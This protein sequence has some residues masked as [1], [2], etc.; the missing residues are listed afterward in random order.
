MVQVQR[1]A[2]HHVARMLDHTYVFVDSR[3]ALFHI[4]DTTYNA[5]LVDLPAIIESQKTL[6]NRQLFKVA[7]ICQMLIVEDPVTTN[8]TTSAP[9]ASSG[10]AKAFDVK[11][12][13]W[14]HGLTPPLRHVRKRRFRKRVNRAVS[15]HRTRFILSI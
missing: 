10:D 14:P 1:L 12:F 15:L 11:D 9:N 4:G 8:D 6:D 13:I 7:D 3:R 5:K 2:S